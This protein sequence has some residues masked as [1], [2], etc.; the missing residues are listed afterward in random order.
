MKCGAIRSIIGVKIPF[1][2]S[3][4]LCMDLF[5]YVRQNAG[6]DFQNGRLCRK[7]DAGCGSSE[8]FESEVRFCVQK[9]ENV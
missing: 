1:D 9:G 2:P 4:L 8:C 6:T 7:T 5:L 3:I